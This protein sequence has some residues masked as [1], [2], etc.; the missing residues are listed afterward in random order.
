[1]HDTLSPRRRGAK[2]RDLPRRLLAWWDVNRRA[3]PWRAEPGEAADP[4]AVWL[5]E[6]LLQ[7]TTVAAATPYFNRFIARW[8]RVEDLAAAGLDEVMRAFAGLGYYSRARNLHACAREIAKAGGAFPEDEASLLKLPGIGAY[9]AAAIAAIAFN[10]PASPVDGNV[11]RIIARLGA[12]EKPIAQSRRIIAETTARL[13]PAERPGDFAQA[14]MDLGATICTPRNPDC[15]LCPLAADCAAYAKGEAEAF[16]RKAMRRPKP[17]RKGAVFFGRDAEGRVLMRTRPPKGLLG[18]TVELPGSEW[19]VDFRSREGLRHAPFA[20]R[21]RRL[22]EA[23]EQAF[24]HFTLQLTIYV[25]R[26]SAKAPAPPGC[27]WVKENEIGS[28]ALSSVMAKAIAHALKCA[29]A[30]PREAKQ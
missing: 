21:W 15:G 26:A 30:E 6:I 20:A 12:L 8:P 28:A 22:P 29:A 27:Y 7:Q 5:S 25:G 3:L 1:M 10:K 16:P 4:Y 17:L 13:I 11:A 18:G 9:T 2:S 19:S 24:T 14:L 23:V